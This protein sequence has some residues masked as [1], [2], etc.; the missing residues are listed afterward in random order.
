M[1]ISELLDESLFQIEQDIRD[2]E[3]LVIDE[4]LTYGQLPPP[5][6]RGLV[7]ET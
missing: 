1:P 2:L 6:G 5:Q 3:E 4:A 7:A